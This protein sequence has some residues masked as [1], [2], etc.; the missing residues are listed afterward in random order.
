MNLLTYAE[1]FQ[2]VFKVQTSEFRRQM[3]FGALCANNIYVVAKY[4]QSFCH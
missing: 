2:R 4:A 3:H 1:F